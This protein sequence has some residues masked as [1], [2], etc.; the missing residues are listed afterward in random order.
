MGYLAPLKLSS[1]T[2]FI[3]T[4]FILFLL[5]NQNSLNNNGKQYLSLLSALTVFFFSL[6]YN[7][8][9]RSSTIEP[10]YEILPDTLSDIDTRTQNVFMMGSAP[11]F[12]MTRRWNLIVLDTYKTYEAC[13]K[14]HIADA[15]C[16]I[17]YMAFFRSAASNNYF[18]LV[19]KE[20]YYNSL[21]NMKSILHDYS[22]YKLENDG[23]QW[24]LSSKISRYSFH[25]IAYTKNRCIII[26]LNIL[27]FIY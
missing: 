12:E 16:E 8:D 6:F 11:F 10:L 22:P 21:L 15:D 1:W 27:M 9:L 7:Q 20:I 14:Y 25:G 4:G 13:L 23:W 5:L 18:A 3:S 26:R 17:L 2:Y 19:S 24:R